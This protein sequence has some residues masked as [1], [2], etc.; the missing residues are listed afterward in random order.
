MI[1]A[2]ATS[3][4]KKKTPARRAD[5]RTSSTVDHGED[6]DQGGQHHHAAEQLVEIEQAVADQGLRQEVEIDDDEDVAER[7]RAGTEI[8]TAA[9]TVA[10]PPTRR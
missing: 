1:A 6:H 4:L 3:V 8:D 5:P 9:V 7:R 2:D 10:T